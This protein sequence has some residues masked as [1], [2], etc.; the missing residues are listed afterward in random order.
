MEDF[1]LIHL[2]LSTLFFSSLLSS[3]LF[4]S[5]FSCLVSPL[6]CLFFFFIFFFFLC[7]SSFFSFL[8]YLLFHLL[9]LSFTA[10][11]D[12]INQTSD[13]HQSTNSQATPVFACGSFC[14]GLQRLA[15]MAGRD[16]GGV[17][18][19][20]RR[21]DR[22]LRAWHRH[23]KMTVAMELAT[24]LHH[25]AQPGGACGGGAGRGGGVRGARRPTG[26]EHSTSGVA[27]GSPEG[28][29][30]AVGRGS[31]GR[32]RGC[33]GSLARRCVGGGA[34]RARRCH[35]PVSP[36]AVAV[37]CRCGGG[38]GEG[39]GRGEGAAGEG[40]GEGEADRGGDRPA[41][42][43][44]RK[45]SLPPPH[46]HLRVVRRQEGPAGEDGEEEEEKEE[47]EQEEAPQVLFNLLLSWCTWTALWARVSLSLF[48]VWCSWVFIAVLVV[49]YGGMCKTGIAGLCA[50]RCVPFCCRQASDVRH[51]GRYVPEGLR[52]HRRFQQWRVQ[53][54]LCWY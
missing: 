3:L 28:S 38:G 27:A 31:H 25:S 18:S 21:R 48:V 34:R 17:G 44:G 2:L 42:G 51:H 47:E 52:A 24:A 15:M 1:L 33:R 16:V 30:A 53:G 4:S 36:P 49:D 5:P 37:G 35:R 19:A 46:P 7:S 6:T 41:A 45:R 11:R 20:R 12:Q 26:T 39:A 29:R 22:Q 8:L 43:P 50:S 9:F 13:S 40:E 23:V 14:V 54:S 32:L 10:H